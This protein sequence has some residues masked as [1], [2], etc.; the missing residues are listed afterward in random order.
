[1][2]DIA[3]RPRPETDDLPVVTYHKPALTTGECVVA[4]NCLVIADQATYELATDFGRSLKQRRDAVEA[5]RVQYTKPLND[6]LKT[7]NGD[8][9]PIIERFDEGIRI[10]KGKMTG[11][12]D[13]QERIQREAQAAADKV[14]REAALAAEKAAK[15]AEKKGNTEVAEAIRET[16]A[17]AA[18]V[19]VAPTFQQ[20]GGT[21]TKK[22]WKGRIVDKKAAILW[23]LEAGFDAMVDI[24]GGKLN[25]FISASGGAAKIAGVD[26]YQDSQVA[27]R[28]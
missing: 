26:T 9:K 24:D 21:A 11:Y 16:A 19:Y 13:E 6:L 4:A 22:V 12:T 17:V 10:T 2:T 20:T 27:L 7:I 25:K 23:L 3:I 15:A 28:K 14:A 8:F 5:K 18:P 1:M